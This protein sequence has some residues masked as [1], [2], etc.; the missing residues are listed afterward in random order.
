[1]KVGQLV[2]PSKKAVRNYIANYI[3]ETYHL[4]VVK[5]HDGR[6]YMM[7][8]NVNYLNWMDAGFVEIDLTF[9]DYAREFE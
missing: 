6:V 3:R 7:R 4:K 5:I 2:K 9:N 8:K 1:M